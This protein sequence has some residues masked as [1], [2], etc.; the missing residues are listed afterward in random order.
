MNGAELMVMERGGGDMLLLEMLPDGWTA[1]AGAASR[2]EM[3]LK[4]AAFGAEADWG[5][6][7]WNGLGWSE[8]QHRVRR[9][10]HRR[11]DSCEATP[12]PAHDFAQ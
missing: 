1:V 6:C 8:Y 9:L 3:D 2:D 7:D 4:L 12:A 11:S 5:G 10:D